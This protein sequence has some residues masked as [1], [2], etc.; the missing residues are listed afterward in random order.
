MN[1]WIVISAEEKNE[2][3]K[4]SRGNEARGNEVATLKTVVK[5]CLGDS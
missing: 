4:G 2:A 5:S 1:S 3:E